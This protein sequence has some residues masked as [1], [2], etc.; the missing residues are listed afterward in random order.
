MAHGFFGAP[1]FA[2]RLVA[3]EQVPL[4]DCLAVLNHSFLEKMAGECSDNE[5]HDNPAADLL[6]N[7]ARHRLLFLACLA[8]ASTAGAAFTNFVNFETAPVHPIAL[9]PDGRTLAVCNLPDNR[10]EL[11]DVSNGIPAST[12]S[13]AVGIDPVTAR[14][15]S[16][17]ELWVVNH[18][19]STI[20]IVDVAARNVVATLETSAGP[21]DVV[22]AGAPRRA[23]VTCSRSNSV[24]VFDVATRA[25]VTNLAIE[26]ERPRAMA[27]SPNGSNVYVAIFESGNGTTVLGRRLTRRTVAPV[28]G[29][30][31][32]AT[33]P[34]AGKDPPPNAGTNFFP[35]FNPNAGS[36]PRVS[37]IVRRNAAGRWLDDNNADWTEFVSGTNAAASARIQGWD[38]ADRDVAIIDTAT[39]T[40]GYAT[41][42]M[43]I[44]MAL[45]VNPASGEIAVVGTDGTNEKRFEPV[46]NGV[47]L[48]VNLAL[49]DPLTRTNRLRDLNPHLDYLTRTVPP[50]QRARSLSDCRGIEWN[51]AGTRAYITGMGSRNMVVVDANGGRVHP[52]SIELG[53]GPT[54]LA[55]DEPRGR[56]YVWNRFS[57]SISVVNIATETVLTNVAVFDPTP[58]I[59]RNGRRHLYDTRKTSGLGLVSCASCH[60]DARG[61]RLAWDLGNPA[62]ATITNRAFTFHPMK[63]PMVTQTLQDIIS[64]SYDQ[65]NI[66]SPAVR[67]D[68]PLHWR[69]DRTNIEDFNG[70]FTNLLANDVSLTTN[71]MAE[72]KSLLASISFPPNFHRTFSNTLPATMPLPGHVGRAV[73][74]GA[75]APLP[76]GR[77]SIGLNVFQQN[78]INCHDPNRGMATTNVW[79]GD[80]RFGSEGLFKLAQLRSLADKV[81]MDSASTNGRAGFGFMH[82]GRIDSL[83]RFIVEGFPEIAF[84]DQAI[85]DVV[86]FLLCFT[87]SDLPLLKVLSTSQDVPAAVGLQATF[88]A[89]S[90]PPLLDDM[91]VLAMRTNSR[92]ELIV[93][94]RANGQ[95]RAWLLRR[96]TADFQSDRHGEVLPSLA[97]VI[98]SAAPGNEFT[99]TLVP[100][101]SGPRLALD[102]D[103]DGY[104]DT[105]ETDSGYNPADPASRP[106][107]IVAMHKSTNSVVLAWESVPGLRYAVETATNLPVSTSNSWST[108]SSLLTATT[109][110]TGYTDAPPALEW[111]RIYRVRKE[112]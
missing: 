25:V 46:L 17:N 54:G 30:V 83:T 84:G 104:F 41:R 94:G 91:F 42:L 102:R 59:V 101:G 47:F 99:A 44:C 22:F 43:N 95:A 3:A 16:S 80:A 62:G 39:L 11:F 77:P 56:L 61:D 33:G 35:V 97:A 53:E 14:F 89:P 82:D 100:E 66:L 13:V 73:A 32:D 68:M 85:A 92:V 2:A 57:S 37:H 75:P 60:V 6:M 103:G 29:P 90:A 21:S 38:L 15:A 98:A 79:I 26:G 40:V 71:E 5:T 65:R 10:V 64:T 8:W 48:R 107:R 49:V 112:P 76:P 7:P 1:L 88:A 20:S 86:S 106:G 34:Y 70:T 93:R 81:G 111:K 74:F 52:Q 55:L 28:S 36:P 58:E 9:G 78:C 24:L 19:S 72:F 67:I 50:A 108:L 31:E 63:G 69:G 87:G 23:W 45:A 51:A 110:V 27:V 18:I 96:A 105:T 109:N 12:A 4:H